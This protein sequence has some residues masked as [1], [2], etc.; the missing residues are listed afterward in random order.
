MN[1]VGHGDCAVIIRFKFSTE[2]TVQALAY[3]LKGGEMDKA[4]LMKLAYL[5]DREHFI[6]TGTSITGD[7]LCAMPFGPV[8]STALNLVDGNIRAN[9]VFKFLHVNNVRVSVIKAPGDDL[10]SD[11]ERATLDGIIRD[12]GNLKTW[13]L[14]HQT[15]KLPEYKSVYVEGTSTTIPFEEIAKH[16]GNEKRFRHNRPVISVETASQMVCPFHRDEDL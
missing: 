3:L 1:G 13:P 11:E 2:K 16:S 12:Y 4:K 6:K 5:A 10:L 9:Y 15:H 7:K 8:P 14:V